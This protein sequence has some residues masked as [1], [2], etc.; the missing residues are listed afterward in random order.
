MKTAEDFK[1]VV[2]KNNIYFWGV[3]MC[4]LCNILCGFL[5]KDGYVF[6]DGGCDCLIS[7]SNIRTTSWNEVAEFYNRQTNPIIISEMNKFWGFE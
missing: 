6:Y 4:S 1:K 5:F 3:D 2:L 7:S